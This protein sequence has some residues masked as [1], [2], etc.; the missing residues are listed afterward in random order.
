MNIVY[1][2]SKSKEF[3]LIVYNNA[4][5]N[6]P[7]HNHVNVYSIGMV[8]SG[9]IKVDIE[10]ERFCFHNGDFFCIPPYVG[11][12]I[13]TDES[14]SMYMLCI[15]K[16]LFESEKLS[17]RLNHYFSKLIDEKKIVPYYAMMF[18]DY[19]EKVE[20]HSL[21]SIKSHSLLNDNL[22]D[23]L[24]INPERSI[25]VE[26]MAK[27]LYLSKFHF[28]RRFK[29]QFG[30][31]PHQYLIQNRIR[32]AQRLINETDDLTEIALA[33]GFCDQSHFI[34]QFEKK[35]MLK[36]SAYK[37]CCLVVND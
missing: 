36:P 22:R 14:Y 6:Y 28:I 13:S 1:I 23:Y 35:V 37:K 4:S 12:A 21:K 2:Q 19:I 27:M 9:K 8:V 24:E 26:D 20:L 11:H 16:S 17:D 18:Q 3:E 5:Y 10:K 29:S 25:T 34:K 15:H 30:L 31:A 7:F 32:K 33:T